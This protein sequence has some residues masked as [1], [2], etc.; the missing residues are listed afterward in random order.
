MHGGRVLH[1]AA[2]GGIV[3]HGLN[4]YWGWQIVRKLRTRW[5]EADGIGKHSA[6]GHYHKSRQS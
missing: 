2:G 3:I 5:R 1:L 6:E 4:G